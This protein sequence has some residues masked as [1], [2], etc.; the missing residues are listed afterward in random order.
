MRT[1]GKH[2]RLNYYLENRDELLKFIC[3]LLLGLSSFFEVLD[4]PENTIFEDPF[5]IGA[6]IMAICSL[7]TFFFYQKTKIDLTY[8]GMFIFILSK[9]FSQYTHSKHLNIFG[10]IREEHQHSITKGFFT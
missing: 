8:P 9:L 3:F 1:N 7:F 2:E 4:N 10:K 6:F 5:C